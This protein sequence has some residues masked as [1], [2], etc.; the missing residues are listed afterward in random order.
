MASCHETMKRLLLLLLLLPLI[1]EASD[2]F[3]AEEAIKNPD[4]L[5]SSVI[6]YLSKNLD[7]EIKYCEIKSMD[8]AF[9]AK[10]VKINADSQAIVVKPKNWCLCGAYYCPM[11]LFQINGSTAN[12]I[13]FAEGTGGFELLDQEANGYRQ[14]KESGATAGHGHESIWTW[15]GEKYRE[16]YSQ[17]WVMDGEKNCR[18]TETYRLKNGKL[19]KVSTSCL[20]D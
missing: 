4:K 11:W 18:E 9:E 17:V 5:P 8:D 6:S 13:W 1:A 20:K 7:E 2:E 19:K 15:D 16:T 12:R 14:I 3:G 10:S